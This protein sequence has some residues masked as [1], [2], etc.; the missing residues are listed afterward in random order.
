MKKISL[1]IVILIILGIGGYFFYN[2]IN[3]DNKDIDALNFKEEHEAINGVKNENNG[4]KYRTILIPEDNPIVYATEDD[5]LNMIKNKETFVV[6]FGYAKCPWCRSVIEELIKVSNDLGL[7][8]LYYVDIE[9]IRDVVEL[10][11][12][13]DPVFISKGTDGY[14]ELLNKLS[15][16]LN[17][18]TLTDKDGNKI[19]TGEKRIYAPDVVTVIEGKVTAMEMGIS[20]LQTDAYMDLTNEMKKD[21][22]KKFEEILMPVVE[23]INTCVEDEGC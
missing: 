10:D 7:E 2:Y 5:I 4:K 12:N 13:N 1:I 9:N 6:Y 16:V 23:K 8:K 3:N 20:E 21:T 11:I 15:K 14:R 19:L 17:D 18:Y 22:Y